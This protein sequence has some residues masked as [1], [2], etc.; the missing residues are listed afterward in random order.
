MTGETVHTSAQADDD[1]FASEYHDDVFDVHG[2]LLA[3]AQVRVRLVGNDQH[4]VVVL[5]LELRPL[6]ALIGSR[7]TIHAEQIFDDAHRKVA[8][9]R[10]A[11][12]K[13]GMRVRITSPLYD[14]RTV[15]PNVQ[16]VVALV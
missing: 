14:M 15:L 16:A 1:L 2:V 11:A 12:L 4:P 7:R 3:D 8:E 13:K 5:C 9:Q 6:C 10:A